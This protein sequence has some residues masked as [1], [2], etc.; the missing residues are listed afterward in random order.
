MT[1]TIEASLD[2]ETELHLSSSDEAAIEIAI[3][4]NDVYAKQIEGYRDHQRRSR[5]RRKAELATFQEA[6][7]RIRRVKRGWLPI[8]DRELAARTSEERRRARW[9]RNKRASRAKVARP[10]ERIPVIAPVT[11]T[12]EC[13]ANRLASLRSWLVLPGPRQRHLRGREGDIM[14]AWV[15]YQDQIVLHAKGPSLAEFARAFEARFKKRMTRQM[16]HNR[17]TLLLSLEAEGGPWAP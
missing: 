17:L 11:I 16:A 14:R 8:S 4:V 5:I 13:F 9:A 12:S 15:L 1:A 10:K 6:G 2:S 3:G 7:E